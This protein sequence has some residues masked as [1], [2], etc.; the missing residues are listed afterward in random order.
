MPL[1][2]SVVKITSQE[3][4]KQCQSFHHKDSLGFVQSE[5]LGSLCSVSQFLCLDIHK[6]PSAF[7]LWTSPYNRSL[8]L[9]CHILWHLLLLPWQVQK[10]DIICGALLNLQ[11]ESSKNKWQ[12]NQHTWYTIGKKS[13]F[14]ECKHASKLKLIQVYIWY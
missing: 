10:S 13:L 8:A 5:Q 11:Q 2:G 12:K 3:T 7:S 14:W 9:C 4:P 1:G 6:L